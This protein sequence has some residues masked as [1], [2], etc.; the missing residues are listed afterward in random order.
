MNSKERVLTALNN[1]IPDQVPRCELLID[2]RAVR[3]IVTDG[4]EFMEKDIFG[5]FHCDSVACLR[6]GPPVFGKLQESEAVDDFYAGG[7]VQSRD[8]LKIIQLSDPYDES[9]YEPAKKFIQEN[10]SDLAK[11]AVLPLALE[12]VM[13]ATGLEKMC[14]LFYDDPYVIEAILDKYAEWMSVA[15]KKLGE[16]GFDFLWLTDDIAYKTGPMFS[17]K[18]FHD[19]VMPY[20]RRVAD[21][22]TL[23]WVFHSDG[24]LTVLF[25]DLLS[26]GMDALHPFEPGTIDLKWFKKEFGKDFCMI[27]NIDLNTLTLGS[28]EDIEK[29]S[30]ELIDMLSEGGGYIMSSANCITDYCK[31]ENVLAMSSAIEKYGK[32]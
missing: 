19:I 3:Q 5:F 29:D 32:Y 12:P 30:K 31:A 6:F 8:D 16:L 22:V 17:P 13:K 7:V 26:L 20:F 11:H 14:E 9:I 21:A 4:R 24:D 27:G 15:V 10:D 28:P 18:I 1:G 25:D 2:E 23:P